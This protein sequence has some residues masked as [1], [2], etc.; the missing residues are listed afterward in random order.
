MKRLL[1]VEDDFAIILGLQYALEQE[2]Y[3]VTV[4]KNAKTALQAAK[5]NTYDLFLLDISLPDHDGFWL[6]EK[7]KEFD[8]ETPALFLT[9]RDEEEA[10]V[11]GLESG[12]ED[13]VTKPFKTRELLLRIQKI[14]K[15]REKNTFLTYRDMELDLDANKVYIKQKEIEFT[16]LEYRILLILVSNHGKVITR[17]I[18]L[19][20]IWDFA[21]NFV[22]DNTLTV[23]IKR[24]R[25]K[26][27]D[28]NYI[29]TI[30]GSGYRLE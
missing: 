5:E 15:R 14:I 2:N 7:I 13:Y 20:H 10:I 24:I 3:C 29:K 18:L 26:L 28:A 17:E 4:C 9:A 1:F 6:Y 19:E 12:A 8:T 23:Y 21:G 22:N 16:A 30:K 27:G 25:E 11:H